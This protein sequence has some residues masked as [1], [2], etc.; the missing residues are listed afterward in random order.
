MSVS[1]EDDLETNGEALDADGPDDIE[2]I[3]FG[4]ILTLVALGLYLG[5]RL[6]EGIVWLVQ[7]I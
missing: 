2:K 6:V 5:W 1:P 7:R 3:P 4:F